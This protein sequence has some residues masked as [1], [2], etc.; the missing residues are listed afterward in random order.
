VGGGRG[1]LFKKESVPFPGQT[2]NE[3][4]DVDWGYRKAKVQLV[5]RGGGDLDQDGKR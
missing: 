2:K 1:V 5:F 3:L 4:G